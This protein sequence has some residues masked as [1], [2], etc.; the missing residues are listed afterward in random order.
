MIRLLSLTSA[1]PD[2]EWPGAG[3]FVEHQLRALAARPGIEV[4]VVAPVGLPPFPLS[5]APRYRRERALPPSES[6]NGLRVHRPRFRQP[7]SGNRWRVEAIARAL[8]PAVQAIRRRFPFDILHAEFFWPDGPVALR[9]ARALGIPFSIKARGGDFERAADGHDWAREQVMEAGAG[10]ARLLAVSRTLRSAMIAC[11]LP[12]DLIAV[13]RTGLDRARF[14]LRDRAAA[15]AA[16]KVE[17]TLLLNVGN[18]VPRKRQHLALESIARL[19]EATLVI[20]GGGPDRPALERHARD[21][22]V[23]GRVRFMGAILQPLMPFFYAAADV[24]VHTAELEGLSNVWVESLACG[25]PVVTTDAGAAREVIDRPA[26]GRIAASD[27]AAIA[28]A[29]RELLWKPPRPEAVAACVDGY[30]WERSAEELEAHLRAAL[31]RA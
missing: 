19:P 29:V 5:L 25:T 4:E 20:V 31:S 21:L 16:L 1:Y 17:G 12:E 14:R 8:H 24:T 13:H 11:G 15:K 18:L 28:A 22:G 3:S 26:A 9:L 6:W 27:P 30:G 7:L 23:D 10:A 2:Q